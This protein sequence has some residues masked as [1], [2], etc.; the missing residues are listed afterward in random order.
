MNITPY[1]ALSV[2]QTICICPIPNFGKKEKK[3]RDSNLLSS[4]EVLL[5][6]KQGQTS[7]VDDDNTRICV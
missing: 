7:M 5:V 4:N 1:A 2:T 3:S 6:N